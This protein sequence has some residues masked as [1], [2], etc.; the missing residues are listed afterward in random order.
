MNVHVRI[1]AFVSLG[2]SLQ[3]LSDDDFQTLTEKVARENPWFTKENVRMAIH[4]VVKLLD[5]PNLEKWLSQYQFKE[6]S[7]KIALVL[8][9]N[10]P[11]VGFHDLLSVL[12]SG[13][14]A[15]IKLSSKDTVLLNYILNTL[16]SIE[17]SFRSR[18]ELVEQLKNFDAVIATGSDNSARYFDYYFSKYPHVIRKNRT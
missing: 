14:V 17:P 7:K 12:I 15:V 13:N 3:Q 10:I 9:G 2:Q 5:K 18:I 11:M 1:N 16:C 4:G 8:A 6:E